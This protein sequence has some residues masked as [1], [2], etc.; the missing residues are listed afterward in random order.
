A[1]K[2][3][4]DGE[5]ALWCCATFQCPDECL[6]GPH[7]HEPLPRSLCQRGRSLRIGS[8][9]EVPRPAGSLH[10]LLLGRQ[11]V[12]TVEEGDHLATSNLVTT[13]DG[14]R[15]NPARGS[16]GDQRDST[17]IELHLT[18]NLQTDRGA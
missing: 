13:H 12:G 9:R 7:G 16:G 6:G 3:C 4:A 18:R 8:A 1:G 5:Q 17:W 2:R 10:K 14:E 11:E 15:F